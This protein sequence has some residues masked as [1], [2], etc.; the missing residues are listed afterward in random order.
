MHAVEVVIF[1]QENTPHNA[2]VGSM[3]Q[4]GKEV[5]SDAKEELKRR[6]GNSGMIA[7]VIS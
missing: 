5:V 1:Q 4:V 2:G 7:C 6:R 3:V